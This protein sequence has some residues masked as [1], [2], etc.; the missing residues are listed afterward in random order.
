MNTLER[1]LLLVPTNKLPAM[2]NNGQRGT[3]TRRKITNGE[4]WPKGLENLVQYHDVSYVLVSFT[5]YYHN[6]KQ[7]IICFAAILERID[8]TS[9]ED[10]KHGEGRYTR[11]GVILKI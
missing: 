5:L 1:I 7:L 6:E 2:A 11:R 10:S 3:T 9:Q 8:S 4:A